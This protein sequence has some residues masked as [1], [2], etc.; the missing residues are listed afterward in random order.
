MISLHHN[1]TN[2][3]KAKSE[4]TIV[5]KFIKSFEFLL[6]NGLA[7]TEKAVPYQQI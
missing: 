6:F 3:V 2:L 1:L 4:E 5:G 7:F